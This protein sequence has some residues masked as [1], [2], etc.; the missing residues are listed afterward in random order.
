[1]KALVT[2]IA[3][4]L[5]DK[6]EKVSVAEMH[7]DHTTVLE[8]TVAKEDIGKIIGKQG[9]TAQAI[10]TILSAVASKNKKRTVLQIIE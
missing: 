2:T 5:V 8:L 4:M 1:M 6:P 9:K 3:Q 10:R 7:G